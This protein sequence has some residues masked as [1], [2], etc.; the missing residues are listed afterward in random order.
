MISV[1]NLNIPTAG[2]YT[3]GTTSDDGSM[4]FIYNNGAWQTVVNN[5]NF[6]GF[7]QIVGQITLTS[8]L[9]PIEI[10][11]YE[12]GGGYF[13]ERPGRGGKFGQP[14]KSE[15]QQQYQ[16]HRAVDARLAVFDRSERARPP[17]LDLHGFGHGP[18][19]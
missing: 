12:G 11:Y 8:G 3:F 4:M 19:V 1:G 10:A 2:T 5:N 14:A 9:H 16:Q 7:T 15:R 18:D 17:V 13:I 6:Q